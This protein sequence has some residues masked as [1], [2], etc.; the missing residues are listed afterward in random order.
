MVLTLL[1]DLDDTLLDTNMDVFTPAYF[2]A[3]AGALKGRVS[4]DS[5]ISALMGG[6][7]RMFANNDPSLT[8][9]QVF[10]IYF[11]PKLGVDRA[12][13]QEDIDRF[14]DEIFPTLSYLTKP[15]PAAVELVE[16]ACAQEY[17]VVIATNPLFPLKAIHHR[18]RWAGLPPE[19]YPFAL[20]TSYENSHFTKSPAYYAEVMVRLG[21]P[22]DPVL[23]V[24]DDVDWDIRSAQALGMPVFQVA[25]EGTSV[26]EPPPN[27][28]GSIADVRQWLENQDYSRFQLSSSTPEA[29]LAIL[30]AVPAGLASLVADVPAEQWSRCPQ[31][32][33]WSLNEISCHLRDVEREVNIPRVRTLL[34]DTNPFFAGQNTDDWVEQRNYDRQDG[35]EALGDLTESRRQLVKILSDLKAEDW[36]RV[37]RHAIFGPTSLQELVGFMTAHDRA[38]VQQIAKTIQQTSN[39]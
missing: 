4:P 39:G 23:M 22:D 33:E 1:L 34:R 32:N 10:D 27:G 24:G 5:M 2:Q 28:Y 31:C 11:F 35:L 3:L 26:A 19:K 9:R 20:V 6:T 12:V 37:A 30:M 25:R 16:W 7:K 14:Y 36:Q 15:R 38:H 29:L 13:L 21:W 18:M 17:R 8:L